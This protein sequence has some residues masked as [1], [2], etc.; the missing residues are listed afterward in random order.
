MPIKY[1]IS[2]MNNVEKNIKKIALNL[3]YRDFITVGLILNKI[4]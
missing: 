4:N 3:P 2:G 1:L